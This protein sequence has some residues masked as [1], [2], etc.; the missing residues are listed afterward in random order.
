[1]NY[2]RIYNLFVEQ[3]KTRNC[4]F[5]CKTH[6]HH[7][8]PRSI[9]GA[10]C[11]ENL[12]RVTER[13]HIFLHLLLTKF[14]QGIDRYCMARAYSMM[15][16]S[17][18][19]V[20][21]IAKDAWVV[22]EYPNVACLSAKTVRDLGR[23]LLRTSD[24]SYKDFVSF[25]ASKIGLKAGKRSLLLADAAGLVAAGIVLRDMGYDSFVMKTF[26]RFMLKDYRIGFCDPLPTVKAGLIER[27]TIPWVTRLL[28]VNC[29]GGVLTGKAY[30]TTKKHLG[31]RLS[32][33]FLLN[34]A[35]TRRNNW[36][37]NIVNNENALDRYIVY[38]KI[39]K[40][41]NVCTA[42][43]AVLAEYCNKIERE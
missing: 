8:V 25:V 19:G 14:T 5:T 16:G 11:A 9:G 30:Q 33:V 6:L 22:E 1:M 37:C 15:G 28:R 4:K 26:V 24:K 18:P 39:T 36:L 2:K 29:D 7:I 21:K 13:E 34:N 10:D 20:V 31:H 35:S 3:W 40:I 38:D 12:V 41:A 17:K 32:N 27:E 23:S 42:T 43:G